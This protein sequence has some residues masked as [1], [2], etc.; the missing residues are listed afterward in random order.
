MNKSFKISAGISLL[1]LLLPVL[2]RGQNDVDFVSVKL[3]ETGYTAVPQSERVY[4]TH[5]SKSDARYIFYEVELN[6]NLYKVENNNVRINA[7]YYNFEDSLVGD[8]VL[9]HT[10][11]PDWETAYLWHGWGW[12][13]PGNWAT[14]RYRVVLFIDNKKLA[15]IF[16]SIYD[17][18]WNY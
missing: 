7:E 15:E 3:F 10:V 17:E 18:D 2:L 16:F 4:S 14:G 11:P 9:D 5:F 8:P 1:V 12:T 13:E 6:N